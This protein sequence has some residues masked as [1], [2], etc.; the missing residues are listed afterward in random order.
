MTN[1]NKIVPLTFSFFL[2][3]LDDDKA[4]KPDVWLHR[5]KLLWEPGAMDKGKLQIFRLVLESDSRA[6]D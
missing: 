2:D 1:Q 5:F 3:D 6:E 4:N